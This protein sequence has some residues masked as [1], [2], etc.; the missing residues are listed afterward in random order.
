MKLISLFA[1]TLLALALSSCGGGGN[2]P[3][4]PPTGGGGG[5]TS[6]NISLTWTAP[7]IY[8]DGSSIGPGELDG[9]KIYVSKTPGDY[10]GSVPII[11]NDSTATS[12]S[13]QPSTSG[14]HNLV[15]TAYGAN[16]AES[17]HSNEISFC[18]NSASCPTPT[19]SASILTNNVVFGPTAANVINYDIV[20]VRYP[21]QGDTTAIELPDGENPYAIEPGADLMLLHPDGTEEILVDCRVEGQ[22]SIVGG[23]ANCSVQDPVISFDGNWVYYSKYVNMGVLPDWKTLSAHSF[24]F[25]MAL[26]VP[27]AQRTEIQLTDFGSGFATS[28]LAGNG[29]GDNITN[30]GIRD[31][32]PTPLPDGR[33][34]FTSNRDAIVAFRQGVRG[35]INAVSAA[36]ASQIHVMDDHDGSIPNKNLHVVGYSNL[37]QAQHPMVLK[38]GRILFTNWDDA[39]LREEYATATLYVDHPDGGHLEQFLEPHHTNKRVEHFATEITSG[40]VVVANYYPRMA[41]WGFGTLLRAPVNITG[42]AFTAGLTTVPD[43]EYRFFTRKGTDELTPHTT[44]RHRA[45][46]DLSGR[47]STP[48]AAPNDSL[49]VSYSTG[50]V[51]FDP[52]CGGC[53]EFP[54]VDAGIYLIANAGTSSIVDPTTQLVMIKNDP[55]YNEMWPR[56]VVPYASMHGVSAPS[57]IMPTDEYAP[58]KTNMG[59]ALGSPVGITGTSSMQNRES[60]PLGRDRFN[61]RHGKDGGRDTGWVVQ[62]TDAGVVQNSDLWGVRI[63][64]M[65]PDRYHAPYSSSTIEKNDG[66]LRDSRMSQHVKGYYSH[67]SENWKILGEFPVRNSNGTA[68]PDGEQDTSWLA[69]IPAD[70]PH[71]IQSIDKYG[72]TLTSEQTWRHVRAG[73]TFASCGGCHAHAKEGVEFTNKAANTPAYQPWDLVNQT[74]MVKVDNQG[75]SQVINRPAIGLWGVE[76]RQDILP[77]LASK[78]ASC[79]S[80]SANQAPAN[81]ARLAMFDTTLSGFDS[82][83]RTYRALAKDAAENFTHGTMNPTGPAGGINYVF[84][85]M[86]RYVRALQSRASYLTWKIYDARLD[87]RSNSDLPG[88]LPIS[89][90]DVD[91]VSGNCPSSTLLNN[92]EKGLISRWID[93]GAP[94]DL[95]R[96]RMRYTDDVLVPS[97]TLSAES[98]PTGKVQIR[99]GVI[100]IESGVDSNLSYIQYTPSGGNAISVPFKNMS[101]DSASGVAVYG[102]TIDANQVTTST[103]MTISVKAYDNAGNH[104]VISKMI[105]SVKISGQKIFSPPQNVTMQ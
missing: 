4:S 3:S 59:L 37:H 27:A 41:S 5:G 18:V 33:L 79:H 54:R 73:K 82:E 78:C 101:F 19:V 102:L 97:L 32:G 13:W 80:S 20:Y 90:E 31:L 56:A 83:V 60:A 65:S 104:Q 23:E 46:S 63:L 16:A 92:D 9:F 6:A 105:E 99:V 93:L 30:F 29:S 39:G 74:P 81:G 51:T 8:R 21:R 28:K 53:I 2:S 71:L 45:P 35:K 76:F 100:D 47:Y 44:G 95:N 89:Y 58:T 77:I 68:D 87:G 25:K 12:H 94:I 15:M 55:A 69:K 40:E 22:E 75:V 34:L 84:P 49:L 10:A 98:S 67:T 64:V 103:P 7:T 48:S 86:S 24:I 70:T 42:P 36:T 11:I 14:I 72:M 38:D 91:F 26:N 61:M 43:D 57:I 17:I 96:P 1:V 85:Q 50:P 66:L 88:S 52:P 62:G